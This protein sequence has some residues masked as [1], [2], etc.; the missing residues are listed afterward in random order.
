MATLGGE[1]CLPRS[2][3][4]QASSSAG[5]R[6]SPAATPQPR[7]S[8]ALATGRCRMPERESSRL[9]LMRLS[10][11]RY[12]TRQQRADHDQRAACSD[13]RRN[14]GSEPHDVLPDGGRP[15]DARDGVR[16]RNIIRRGELH[17]ISC[18]ARR[19]L[20]PD[21]VIEAVEQRVAK[22]ELE[23]HVFVELAAL[24]AGRL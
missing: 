15:R 23:K 2:H 16:V 1:P 13:R 5:T 8:P 6:C 10:I 3:S 4:K 11:W 7:R 20:D 19:R 22:G 9:S 21:E 12:A 18:D 14:T 17:D 24:I